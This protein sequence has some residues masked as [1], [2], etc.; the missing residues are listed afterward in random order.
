MSRRR[1]TLADY[2]R[3]ALF[4]VGLVMFTMVWAL[5][6]LL[7]FV[8]PY[9]ARYWFVSRWC[10]AM[11]WWLGVT[12]GLRYEMRGQENIPESPCIVFSKHESAWE[13]IT[14]PIHFAPQCWVLKREL[15]R[16]PFFGWGLAMLEPIAIDRAAGK[17][18]LQ[19]VIEQGRERIARGAWVVVFPEGTRVPPGQKRRYKLG[20]AALAQATGVPVLPIALD[21][22]DYW[23]R[24]SFLKFPG[25]IRVRIGPL[26]ATEGLSAEGINRTAERWIED[27]VQALRAERH[28]PAGAPPQADPVQ[29]EPSRGE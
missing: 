27:N 6:S 15:L 24:N 23:P 11:R 2:L 4:A 17:S 16:V 9:R 7:T 13:T 20:G 22:G 3:S 12:V 26:I 29:C 1:A 8:A 10:V 18:A 21:S 28:E 25:T 5:L 14:F 19:Q